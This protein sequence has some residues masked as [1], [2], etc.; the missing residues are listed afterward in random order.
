VTLLLVGLWLGALVGALAVC[1]VQ[2][3][4]EEP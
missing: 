4:R 3:A 1:L 2:L